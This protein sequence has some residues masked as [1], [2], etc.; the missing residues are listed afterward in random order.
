[1]CPLKSRRPRYWTRTTGYMVRRPHGLIHD[2]W[3]PLLPVVIDINA[4]FNRCEYC[5]WSSPRAPGTDCCMACA[6]KP[7]ASMPNSNEPSTADDSPPGV[8]TTRPPSWSSQPMAENAWAR[9]VWFD[10]LRRQVPA[11]STQHPRGLTPPRFSHLQHT[12]GAPQEAQLLPN[13][14]T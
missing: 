1:M 5:G 14:S 6:K 7:K 11:P 2:W 10:Q 13:S 4:G 8:L 9:H 3:E 12:V